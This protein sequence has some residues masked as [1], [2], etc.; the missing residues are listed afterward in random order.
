MFD[1]FFLRI[2]IPV[3]YIHILYSSVIPDSEWI[4][5]RQGS[6]NR[7]L[8]LIAAFIVF[9]FTCTNGFSLLISSVLTEILLYVKHILTSSSATAKTVR[10]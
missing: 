2:K 5:Q 7:I 6:H 10:I 3:S 9:Y 1:S 8:I 4:S